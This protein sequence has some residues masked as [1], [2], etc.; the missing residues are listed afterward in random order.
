M[1]K[2]INILFTSSGR[3]VALI[4]HFKEIL[5]SIRPGAKIITADTNKNAPTAFI[6]D[7]YEPVPRVTDTNYISTLLEICNRHEIRLLI[8]LIDTELLLLSE[9]K[10]LFQEHGVTI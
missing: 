4:R 8:P 2:P 10:A 3:R 1:D 6:G 7:C 5:S 9:H